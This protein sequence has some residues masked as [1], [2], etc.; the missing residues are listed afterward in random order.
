[1]P[2]DWS[3]HAGLEYQ[4]YNARRYTNPDLPLFGENT[5]TANEGIYLHL[6]ASRRW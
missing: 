1:M 5:R 3:L 6:M 4:P 2:P